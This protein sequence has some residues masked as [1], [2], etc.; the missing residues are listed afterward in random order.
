MKPFNK[1]FLREGASSSA[2]TFRDELERKADV[3]DEALKDLEQ[4]Y[5]ANPL[6]LQQRSNAIFQAMISDLMNYIQENGKNLQQAQAENQYSMQQ[7]A[8]DINELFGP[9]MGSIANLNGDNLTI[10]THQLNYPELSRPSSPPK[11]HRIVFQNIPQ[12]ATKSNPFGR[13]GQTEAELRK[14]D[15]FNNPPKTFEDIFKPLIGR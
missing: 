15:R 12:G 11:T 4:K 3:L 2:E 13:E 6:E 5:S 7:L 10:G 8:Q 9:Y 14:P 1:F